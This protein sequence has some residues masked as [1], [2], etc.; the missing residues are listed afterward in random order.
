MPM[1]AIRSALIWA[2]IVG[3]I[4]LWLPLLAAMRLF[5]RDPVHY[6]VGRMFRRLGAAMTRV[7]PFWEISFEG[8]FPED[9]R[10][11][12]VVVS[13]HQSLGDIA[14]ISRLPWEMKWVAK[15]EL[16]S[17]PFAGWMM[18]MAGDIPVDRGDPKS[19]SLVVKRARKV[20]AH[21]C[22]VMF[23]PEGTRS[24]DA[25]VRRFQTGAFRLA[26]E[27]GVPVLPI[28]VDGTSDAIPKHG[29]KF[30]EG[31]TARVGL[32]EPVETSGWTV[33]E[34]SELASEVRQRI[35]KQIAEW[36]GTGP[37]TVDAVV[38]GAVSPRSADPDA[39]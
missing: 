31:I 36:R 7:N 10:H 26:I 25:R 29:W 13:N 24:K 19:R 20:L 4:V 27:A 35:I 37:E 9:P 15:A 12:Y 17:L 16:F 2:A 32:L 14:V 23:F 30:G 38:P 11:P 28:A 6:A 34:A 22:S 33:E 5:S 1:N 3:L 8:S 21:R 18:K 39:A